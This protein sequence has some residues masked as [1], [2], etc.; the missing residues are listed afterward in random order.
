M[1]TDTW[2]PDQLNSLVGVVDLVDGLA[3]HA[4]A[5]QRSSYRPV[6]FCGGDPLKLVDHYQSLGIHSVYIADLASLQGCGP[7]LP[8]LRAIAEVGLSTWFDLGWRGAN[9]GP[10]METVAALSAFPEAQFIA[11]TESCVDVDAVGRLAEL[12][13]SER[14]WLGLDYQSGVIL[15]S[16]QNERLWIDSAL[17]SN[18]AGVLVLD[19]AAVGTGN[20]PV[21]GPKCK[22]IHEQAPTLSIITGGGV[23]Q[24]ADVQRLCE[25]GVDKVLVATALYPST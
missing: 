12:V 20:G 10:L 21:T 11:A 6:A 18:L 8:T 17:A 19:L 1:T 5:G 3:V 4:V 2:S 16:Q 25:S 7:Q 15:G 14:T 22:Q 13:G 9:S 24:A 23:R